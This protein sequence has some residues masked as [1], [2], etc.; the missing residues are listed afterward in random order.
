MSSHLVNVNSEPSTYAMT[1][2]S[3]PHSNNKR[4]QAKS[5]ISTTRR[6]VDVNTDRNGGGRVVR[7]S[8]RPSVSSIPIP[9]RYSQRSICSHKSFT[10]RNDSSSIQLFIKHHEPI[11][12]YRC[13][14][15]ASSEHVQRFRYV[16]LK[17]ILKMYPA[18]DKTWTLTNVFFVS[19]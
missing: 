15:L 7:R 8:A 18:K 13:S 14:S 1:C 12:Y 17:F 16:L 10:A 11:C 2:A 9:T 5:E 4:K 3:P 6:Y 19:V